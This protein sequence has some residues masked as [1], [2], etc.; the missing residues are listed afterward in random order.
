MLPP[1]LSLIPFAQSGVFRSDE[2]AACD[3]E[4]CCRRGVVIK[5]GRSFRCGDV[6]SA[7]IAGIL[8][9]QLQF[10]IYGK[11]LA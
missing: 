7:A 6:S 9:S 3:D 8:A 11:G 5:S 10:H 4:R 1:N 2:V